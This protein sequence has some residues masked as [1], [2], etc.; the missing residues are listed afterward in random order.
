VRD[1]QVQSVSARYYLVTTL[2]SNAVTD[3]K[4]PRAWPAEWLNAMLGIYYSLYLALSYP[5]INMYAGLWQ[6]G[7]Q[8]PINVAQ[9]PINVVVITS[10][11]LHN[12]ELQQ[13][14]LAPFNKYQKGICDCN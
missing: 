10:M 13:E 12:A 2:L 5:S 6:P 7:Q 8:H 9:H 14:G 3:G 4:R 11:P 1:T